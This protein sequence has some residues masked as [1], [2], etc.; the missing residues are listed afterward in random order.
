MLVLFLYTGLEVSCSQWTFTIL[1]E[2]RSVNPVVA[3]MAVSLFWTG[4]LFGRLLFGAL[5]DRI[6]ADRLVRCSLLSAVAGG[7]LFALP[8]LPIELS[9]AGLCL[10][11]LGLAPVFPCLI[12]R[13][14]KR[15]G[16]DLASQAIGL[17]VGSA[18][19]GAAAVPGTLGLIAG[20]WGLIPVNFGISMLLGILFFLHEIL[21]RFPDAAANTRQGRTDDRGTIQ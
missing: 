12:S 6:G 4:L 13:T 21:L 5:V 14:P 10:I 20:H 19:I 8:T 16:P 17:Q 11:G 1:T 9:L 15:L 2:S 7:S 3:G 18:M